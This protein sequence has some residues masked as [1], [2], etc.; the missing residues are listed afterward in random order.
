[1]TPH[2][3]AAE[4]A[5]L[6]AL[7]LDPD[8]FPR[9]RV[10]T[11]DF[12]QPGHRLI[13]A[14]IATLHGRGVAPDPV[15]V[16]EHLE[17]AGELAAT[18]GN[19]HL[20]ALVESVASASNAAAYA[21][22]VREA[23]ILR[24]VREF[25]AQL[26]ES[27]QTGETPAAELVAD[28]SQKLLSFQQRAR[29]GRGLTEGRQ[30]AQDLVDDL[31]RRGEGERG[32]SIGLDDF[33]RLSYGLD[34]GDLVVFAGRPGMG[35][36]ALLVS[37]AAHVSRSAGVAV[38]SA[39]M[40][41]RQ[42]M[43]R[44]AALLGQVPQGRFRR[45]DQLTDDDWKAVERATTEIS[46]RRLWIDDTPLPAFAHIRSETLALKARAPLGLVLVDYVQLVRGSGANRYEQLREVAYGLLGLAKEASVPVILLAQLNRSVESRDNR[47]PRLAD[48]RDSGAIEEAADMVGMLYSEG[49]YNPDC[50][51]P[52]VLECAIEKNR[53]GELGEC[54]WHFAGEFS[55]VGMLEEG[56]RAQYRRERAKA[57]RGADD[58][59]DL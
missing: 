52:Y 40:S 21:Q 57:R 1:M 9:V 35:K 43:R 53:G 3:D 23:A 20:A 15:T 25:A 2:A 48:L 14:A 11:S 58:D 45:A 47:R 4:C 50:G 5:L 22:A 34:P 16:G 6:G 56:A 17:R 59:D 33:D 19:D 49:Y 12:R 55:R 44:C 31:D 24:Q 29:G 39:E 37:I 51:M 54:L 41:S 18:G 7:M 8:I 10:A 46:K 27:A 32:L 30:L 42:L 13:F 36:T 28:A 38:F 26:A